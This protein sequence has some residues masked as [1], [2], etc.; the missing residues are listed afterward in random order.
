MIAAE[1]WTAQVLVAKSTP[2]AAKEG[3][4]SGEQNQKTNRNTMQTKV[5]AQQR[6]MLVLAQ[7]S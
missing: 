4:G 5:G 6:T 1:P 2:Y 3:P 7:L